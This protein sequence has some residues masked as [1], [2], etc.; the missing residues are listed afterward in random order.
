MSTPDQAERRALLPIFLIVL[1][2]ILA[3]ILSGGGICRPEAG[4]FSNAFLL[5]AIDVPPIVEPD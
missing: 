1:V 3:G 2:D 4:R 5:V